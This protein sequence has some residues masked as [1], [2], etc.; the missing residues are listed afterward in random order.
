MIFFRSRHKRPVSSALLASSSSAPRLRQGQGYRE[1]NRSRSPSSVGV[2][3]RPPDS[4]LSSLA[5]LESQSSSV[6]GKTVSFRQSDRSPPLPHYHASRHTDSFQN[7]PP[8][9]NL[10]DDGK[11]PLINEGSASGAARGQSRRWSKDKSRWDA[12]SS[13]D[14]HLV[15]VPQN[16]S[17]ISRNLDTSDFSDLGGQGKWYSEEA[18]NFNPHEYQLRL[19]PSAQNTLPRPLKPEGSSRFIDKSSTHHSQDTGPS[20]TG[21]HKHYQ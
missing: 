16:R 5:P 7:G 18:L 12:Q 3:S 8:T 10:E 6:T 14:R 9:R 2:P 11:P 13:I 15:S 21:A 4:S 1:R 20:S 17:P 19:S